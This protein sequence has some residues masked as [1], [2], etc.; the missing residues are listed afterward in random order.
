MALTGSNNEQ[1]IWNYL[2][3]KGLS[4]YGAAG[5]MGNLYAESALEPTNLQNSYEKSLGYT[6][7]SYTAAVDNGSY[8]NFVRD[9]AGY[10][11]AQW[12]YWSRKE[13]MLNFA[14]AAGKSIGDL[15]MQLDFL[16][17]ELSESY[18]TVLSTL[19]SAT[20]VKAASDSVLLNFERPADQSD[21]VKTKRAGYG[22]TYYDKYA[23]TSGSTQTGGTSTMGKCY[24]STVI[25]IAVAEIG[26][27]EKASNSNLDNKTANA[28]SNNYTKYAN[29]F[30]NEC[31]NWYNGKKNGYAWCDMFVDWCFHM[32]Y[33][34]EDAL[35]LLCQ[36]EKSAGAGCTYSYGYYKAKGQVGT[37]PRVGAQIFFGNSANNLSHTGI[38]EKFDATYVYTI[39]GNTSDM[40]ARRTYKRTD[41]YVFGYGYPAFDGEAG[42]STGSSGSTSGSSGS[43]SSGTTTSSNGD[44]IYTVVSGDTLSKIAAKYGT[45]YQKLAEYNGISN[46][47]V[48]NV[49]QKIK[50]PSG[51]A[52]GGS[53][54]SA[55]ST[56][57]GS[58]SSSSG[59]FKVGDAVQFSG[60]KHY[61]SANATSGS[62]AKAGKAT[63]T[64]YSA[65][66][67]HPYHV[68]HAD[69]SSNVYGWVDAADIGASSSGSGTSSASA[70]TTT[71]ATTKTHK[72]V[73]GDT[74]SALAS[75][76]G[77]TVAKI[78]AA[79]KS[80]YPTMTANYIVVGWTLTM[81][82]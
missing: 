31:P 19:K 1:K 6:D 67:K 43:G 50:I 12:T 77:T 39:E 30:D 51:N 23:G 42:T 45:T 69:S 81:P 57:T 17:K 24:A 58:N 18:K 13:N 79:N 63:I 20:S 36:P 68:I 8:G 73:K 7:A 60:S 62:S 33:G 61:A 2:I 38:V 27:K 34:H 70:N 76:Y 80:K 29:Y 64:A 11:L 16:Y 37:T 53:S 59:S 55:G 75:K 41:S 14:R 48:I 3:A 10:G 49:G 28:G 71:S 9:S 22:Q 32:A 66:A 52:S 26:Y 74:L 21:S 47:N 78:V 40:V 65:G 15:E 4:K 54:T 72:V 44:I 56:S 5:L 82:Q 25:A 46:P 35:R